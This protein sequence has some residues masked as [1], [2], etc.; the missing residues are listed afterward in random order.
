LL[1]FSQF[2]TKTVAHLNSISS[3][4]S[5]EQVS[6]SL[7]HELKYA[8]V[9]EVAI[10]CARLMYMYGSIPS[11]SIVASVPLHP[12]RQ[13]ERGF[14]QAE[15]IAQELAKLHK[16]PYIRLLKRTRHTTNLASIVNKD[17]RST[18]IKDQFELVAPLSNRA[19]HCSVLI[20]D[21]VWTSGAT[22]S[23]AA[24]VLKKAGIQSVH[25]LTFAHGN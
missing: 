14:N 3:L 24:R 1:Q 13:N 7:I 5:L 22:L 16:L 23:E 11:V 8:S 21:D 2:I 17:V 25:G 4:V 18:I 15:E 6:T 9:K 10:L 20:I 12:I 19:S